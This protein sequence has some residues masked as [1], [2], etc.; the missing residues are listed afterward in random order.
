MPFEGHVYVMYDDN[1][2]LTPEKSAGATITLK[3]VFTSSNGQ[4]KTLSEIEESQYN[5]EFDNCMEHQTDDVKFSQFRAT[6]AKS[7][8]VSATYKDG[9][10]DKDTAELQ[11]VAYFYSAKEMYV[12]VETSTEYGQLGE[13]VVIIHLRSY[14]AFHVSSYVVKPESYGEVYLPIAPQVDRI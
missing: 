2:V 10:D 8:R 9:E 6:D 1:Q 11:A 5:K 13:N 3:P 4:L 14:L 7:M 12:H